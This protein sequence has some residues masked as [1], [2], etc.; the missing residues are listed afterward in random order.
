MGTA[1][2]VLQ[3]VCPNIC[4]YTYQ[5]EGGSAATVSSSGTPQDKPISEDF[6][7]PPISTEDISRDM[8]KEEQSLTEGIELQSTQKIENMEKRMEKL[9]KDADNF[10]KIGIGIAVASGAALIIALYSLVKSK[11]SF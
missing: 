7:P 8:L 6:L 2:I 4:L 11:K 1:T 10:K 5:K 9:E 3:N